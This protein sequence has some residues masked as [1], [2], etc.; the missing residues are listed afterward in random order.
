[1]SRAVLITGGSRGIGLATARRLAAAG[2]RIVLAARSEADLERAV[3]EIRLA[4]AEAWAWAGD[5]TQP[6]ACEAMVQHARAT[7][8]TIDVCV[9][10]AGI[11][12]WAPTQSM[13]D[14][15]WRS[16]MAVNVDAA[17][18]TTRAVLPMMTEAGRGHL[19][20]VSSVLGRRGVP[21]MAAYA[22]SKAAVSAFAE[23]VAAEVKPRGVK[24]TVF[25]PG[26]TATGMRDHQ[27]MRPQTPDITDEELQ[28][29]PEDVAD[30]IAWA[31]GVS[32]R[33]YPT[34]VTVE[35]RGLI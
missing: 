1:M 25:Y 30:A 22:A 13:T 17:F 3:E 11:G 23:S 4:G 2:D 20:Y 21:N 10:G 32:H 35:P 8:G 7:A 33:A 28:L 34:A 18:Y 12:H 29:A 5:V 24:V 9:L 27:T 6:D 19:C 16:T 15:Q 26:T 14:E 31:I